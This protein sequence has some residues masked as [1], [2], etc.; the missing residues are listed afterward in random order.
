MNAESNILEFIKLK[1]KSYFTETVYNYLINLCIQI[2]KIH[3]DNNLYNEAVYNAFEYL[4]N[5]LIKIDYNKIQDKSK[6]KSFLYTIIKQYY[7]RE[8]R[9]TKNR[10]FN[11]LTTD[12]ELEEYILNNL[13][14]NST[15]IN[16][17]YKESI[18]ETL[19]IIDKY[20]SD[21]QTTTTRRSKELPIMLNEI[22][23]Y[24]QEE[25]YLDDIPLGYYL[26]NEKGYNPK[27]IYR[28][29]KKTGIYFSHA[30]KKP[31]NELCETSKSNYRIKLT[32]NR[33]K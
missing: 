15:Y 26:L 10:I 2:K 24:I 20:I 8:H 3:F 19:F 21:I 32:N 14:D 16:E 29:K 6:I 17:S 27:I 12:L 5:E 18:V 30:G 25:I 22:K 23:E 33:F 1:D 7:S 13:I 31:Y 28:L 4:Y 11:N 9:A